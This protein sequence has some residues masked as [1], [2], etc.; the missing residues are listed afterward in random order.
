MGKNKRMQLHTTLQKHNFSSIQFNSNSP[1]SF[2]ICVCVCKSENQG[3]RAEEQNESRASEPIEGSESRAR[4][5]PRRQGHWRS[6][7]QAFQN[8][9]SL[10][11]PSQSHSH[12]H[13]LL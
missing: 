5:P 6:P 4:S 7:K 13:S 3:V 12:S 2:C 1:F 9:S 11:F 8:V 10:F